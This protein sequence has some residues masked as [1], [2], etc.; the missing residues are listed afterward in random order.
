MAVL[1]AMVVLVGVAAPEVALAALVLAEWVL[2]LA[3]PLELVL[4]V[5]Q[6]VAAWLWVLLQV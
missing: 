6:L 1:V 4:P 2:V 5:P 3:E